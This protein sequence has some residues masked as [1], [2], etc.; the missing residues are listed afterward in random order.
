MKFNKRHNVR[1]FS[2][3]VFLIFMFILLAAG[4]TAAWSQKKIKQLEPTLDQSH[5][6]YSGKILALWGGKVWTVNPNN[7]Q[8]KHPVDLEDP[9]PWVGI[10]HNPKNSKTY[11]LGGELSPYSLFEYTPQDEEGPTKFIGWLYQSPVQACDTA[12]DIE[13]DPATGHL[14]CLYG[15]TLARA[16][17]L[18]SSKIIVQ[19]INNNLG[20]DFCD[21]CDNH[22]AHSSLAF[23]QN[24]D[25]YVITPKA[26]KVYK[27]NKNNGT[28]INSWSFSAAHYKMEETAAVF[29]DGILFSYVSDRNLDNLPQ[30]QY[31][32]KFF[33]QQSLT[34]RQFVSSNDKVVT[35][36]TVK[37]LTENLFRLKKRT[38]LKKK[39]N[40]TK[41][42]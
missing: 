5:Q 41:K 9:G 3:P 37:Y 14:Y 34:N 25:L 7:G 31:Y 12:R 30:I 40:K 18:T 20:L 19:T 24:G 27:I 29:L 21:V 2:Q 22:P 8:L 33:R 38:N 28:I 10:A 1:F 11:V 35:D 32:R 36:M 39:I 4:S 26:G 42:K 16:T 15:K 17:D 13:F 6:L 23:K